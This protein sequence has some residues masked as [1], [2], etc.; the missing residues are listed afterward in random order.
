VQHHWNACR[1]S[2]T[3]YKKNKLLIFVSILAK[4]I[5]VEPLNISMNP[6]H[7]IAAS[8]SEFF[9]WNFRTPKSRSSLEFGNIKIFHVLES[10]DTF[11]LN[12]QQERREKREFTTLTT[13]LQA[14]LTELYQIIPRLEL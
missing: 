4:F 3:Q 13:H 12:L 9:V 7:V 1:Q 8:K 5:E 14:L 6:T 11:Y 10:N 2:V